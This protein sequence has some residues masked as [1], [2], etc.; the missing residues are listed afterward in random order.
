MYFTRTYEKNN[1]R[2]CFAI[3]LLICMIFF[4]VSNRTFANA[5][6]LGS[7]RSVYSYVDSSNSMSLND[8]IEIPREK[9]QVINTIPSFGFSNNIHWIRTYVSGSDFKTGDLWLKLGPSFLDHLTVYYKKSDGK[10][11]WHHK[12]FGD[13][14]IVDDNDIVS[15][16]YVLILP[17]S[18]S[19]YDLV[20][21]IKSTSTLIFMGALSD[22]QYFLE[23]TAMETALWSFYFGMSMVV[24]AISLY[25]AIKTRQRLFWGLCIFSFN[26]ILVAA[27]HGFPVWLLGVKFRPVQ[28]YMVSAL[29]LLGYST[30]IWL[31]CEIFQLKKTMRLFYKILTAAM[32]ATILLQLS[33]PFGLYGKAI[34]IESFIFSLIAPLL[35]I[36]SVILWRRQEINLHTLLVGLMPPVYV[37]VVFFIILTL[38]G[39]VPFNNYLSSAWQ[40]TLLVH[41]ISVIILAGYRVRNEHRDLEQK[42]KIAQELRIE[43][44]ATFN[45]RRFLGMVAHEYKNPL[46]IMISTLSDLKEQ[47][48]WTLNKSRFER[49]ERAVTRL[50]QLSENC[51]VE[52][53]LLSSS[54]HI[55]KKRVSLFV[56]IKKAST[57]V[58]L[59]ERHNMV[60]T[61]NGEVIDLDNSVMELFVDPEL[62]AIAIS[63]ILDNS[64]KYTDSGKIKIDV[65]N[66][67]NYV[68]ISFSDEGD[69]IP[70]E[71]ADKIFELFYRNKS[72]DRNI[73]G[74]GLGLYV[75]Q[76]IVRAHGGDLYLSG[77]EDVAN[78]FIIRLDNVI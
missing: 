1:N 63:N 23:S 22:P 16:D 20:F 17:S 40:F 60:V 7:E 68:E 72:N 73:K 48:I 50:T 10:D 29:S 43:R 45:Q 69:G 34:Q 14:A 31:H 24:S 3:N 19:G 57:V 56:I 8:F 65:Y 35:I 66:S 67:V 41:A 76:Q 77:D 28:D 21:K 55:E 46:A 58:E 36:S 38:N 51:L 74:T 12:E 62:I 18:L 44:N 33:I 39:I 70:I 26:Y 42:K 75:S 54:L 15:R 4:C 27:L 11:V 5:I 59:S 47:K 61:F 25:F 37:I 6:Q 32:Y 53:R 78:K 52:A 13:R 64:V 9:L 71:H 30:A 2:Q 49:I